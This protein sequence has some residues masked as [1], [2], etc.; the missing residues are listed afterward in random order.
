MKGP[1]NR[2]EVDVTEA[3]ISGST[4]ASLVREEVGRKVTKKGQA[5]AAEVPFEFHKPAGGFF[6]ATAMGG[7]EGAAAQ[8]GSSTVALDFS[9]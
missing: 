8:D 5:Q 4:Y 7:G 1:A 3:R 6:P 9:A 2:A